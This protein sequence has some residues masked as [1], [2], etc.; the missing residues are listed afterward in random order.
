MQTAERAGIEPLILQSV[1]H[2]TPA[3]QPQGCI[4][5]EQGASNKSQLFKSLKV[6][7]NNKSRLQPIIG[8]ASIIECVNVDTLNREAC[9]LCGVCVCRL[10]KADMRNHILGS[11]HRFNYIVSSPV[12]ELDCKCFL[13][14]SLNGDIFPK[15]KTYYS[16]MV[17][18]WQ[19]SDLSKLAWPL[20][21]LANMLEGQEGP[22]DVQLFEVDDFIYQ[23]IATYSENGAITLLYAIKDQLGQTEK[24]SKTTP[25]RYPSESKRIV[26]PAQNQMRTKENSPPLTSANIEPSIKSEF[27]LEDV[28]SRVD[29]T[30]RLPEPLMSLDSNSFVDYYTGT[31]PLIGLDRVVEYRSEGGYSYCF[32]CH[33]CR[34]KLNEKNLT[35]HLTSS[36]HL[37]NYLLEAYPEQNE[38]MTVSNEDT[39]LLQSLAKKVDQEEGKGKLKVINV[40]E[41]IC[42]LLTGKSYHWCIKMLGW[43]PSEVPKKTMTIKGLSVNK[44]N[45]QRAEKNTKSH[46]TINKKRRNRKTVFNVSLPGTKGLVLLK[47]TPF[48]E[49]SLPVSPPSPLYTMVSNSPSESY[50]VDCEVECDYKLCEVNINEQTSQLERNFDSDEEAQDEAF[51]PF[52]PEKNLTVTL[53]QDVSG[54]VDTGYKPKDRTST[55]DHNVFV[56]MGNNQHKFQER[57]NKFYEMWTHGDA[58]TPNEGLLPAVH[59]TEDRSPYYPPGGNEHCY[60]S[61]SES[62]AGTRVDWS[63]GEGHMDMSL[64]A[65]YY[66]QYFQSQYMAWYNGCFSKG[67]VGMDQHLPTPMVPSLHSAVMNI[68]NQSMPRNTSTQPTAHFPETEQRQYPEFTSD[69]LQSAPQSYRAQSVRP[70]RHTMDL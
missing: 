30:V 39:E 2:T 56:K 66:H 13:Y 44:S 59:H 14:C 20:M 51:G 1:G 28:S 55:A 5:M 4:I 40:P 43:T 67:S 26:L 45:G 46:K 36:S 29:P 64:N 62:N 53:L 37:I 31:K 47:R 15:Q 48:R 34:I 6:Y 7:L 70:T 32:L 18:K 49:D 12:V 68:Q 54:N 42:K 50:S 10:S 69:F 35:E 27:N 22:G 65:S 58:Q 21:E 41:S 23:K 38:L 3:P 52:I 60:N 16:H 9:Y 11:L 19:E 25:L 61:T 24:Y 17:S 33:C 63:R 57:S 8:L